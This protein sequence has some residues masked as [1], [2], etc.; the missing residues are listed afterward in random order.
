MHSDPWWGN[1]KWDPVIT[2]PRRFRCCTMTGLFFQSLGFERKKVKVYSVNI[3]AHTWERAGVEL[4]CICAVGCLK[5]G[6]SFSRK[7]LEVSSGIIRG[8]EKSHKQAAGGECSN[9]LEKVFQDLGFLNIPLKRRNRVYTLACG[10]FEG[11]HQLQ[12]NTNGPASLNLLCPQGSETRHKK[13]RRRRWKWVL[14]SGL[15]P[16][17]IHILKLEF[18]V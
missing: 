13:G 8:Y 18:P 12:T 15:C 14:W 16:P 7:R 5:G 11:S 2:G 1:P 9:Y 4:T 3:M 10:E 6:R 17:Q